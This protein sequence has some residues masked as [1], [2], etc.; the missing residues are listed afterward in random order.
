MK[1]SSS[2]T[3]G[4]KG[5]Y[6]YD[7]N[8]VVGSYNHFMIKNTQVKFHTSLYADEN[9]LDFYFATFDQIEGAYPIFRK[10]FFVNGYTVTSPCPTNIRAGIANFFTSTYVGNVGE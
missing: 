10:S 4:L 7:M 8:D 5:M 1:I 2:T 9:L 3:G 6:A